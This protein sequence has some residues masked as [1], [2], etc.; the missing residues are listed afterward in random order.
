MAP[1]FHS[2]LFF[3]PDNQVVNYVCHFI[4]AINTALG[5]FFVLHSLSL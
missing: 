1:C 5:L 4:A 3:G 2:L